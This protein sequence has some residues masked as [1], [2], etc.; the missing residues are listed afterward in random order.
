L[1]F[2]TFPADF[3]I[4]IIFS[5][6]NCSNLLDLR[7]L[8]EQMFQKWVWPFTVRINCSSDLKSFENSP[9]SV[10]NFKSISQ[11]L[12]QFFLTVSQSNFGNKIPFPSQYLISFLQKLTNTCHWNYSHQ[13]HAKIRR[14]K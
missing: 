9:L 1:N 12:E 14:V 3:W 13:N 7:N 6:C 11:S 10:S 8:Q 4:P 2:L 5:N